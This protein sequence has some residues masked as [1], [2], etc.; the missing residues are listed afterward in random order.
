MRYSTDLTDSQWEII[1]PLFKRKNNK[2]KHLENQDKREL[3]NAVLY[4]NKT[5][6]QWRL[7]PSDF[8]NYS[9]VSS[10]YHRAIKSGLW[11]KIRALLVSKSR[12]KN[13]RNPSPTYALE[14]SQSSKTTGA[15]EERGY[16]G[17]KKSKGV[18]DI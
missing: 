14:D 18:K 16:D 3:V 15:S 8:P 5:G 13:K 7:L 1:A 10:F 4:I 17:G 11:D 12:I 2:G 6:C 9:T